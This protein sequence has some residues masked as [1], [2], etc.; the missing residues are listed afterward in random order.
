[1]SE[2]AKSLL[3]AS[4]P[5]RSPYPGEDAYFAANPK[6]TGMA[7][8]DSA[9]VLNPYSGL[10]PDRQSAVALNEASRLHMMDNGMIHNF[11]VTESQKKFFAGSPY[12]KDPQ[13]MRHTIVARN[14][15]GDQS[16]GPYTPDQQ[17]ASSRVLSSAL[18]KGAQP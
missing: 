17:A 8:S 2:L 3:S 4:Y 14:I 1:M 6:T 5:V 11:P 15:S 10:S 9:V 7:A 18:L 16:A 12:E 13:M